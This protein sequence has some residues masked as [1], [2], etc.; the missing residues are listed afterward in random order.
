MARDITALFLAEITAAEGSCPIGLFR[1]YFDSGTLNLWT[2]HGDLSYGGVTYIG[3]N[4]VL[5][6]GQ[7]QERKSITANGLQIQLNGLDNDILEIAEDEPYQDRPFEMYLAVINSAGN[8]VADPYL[9]FEGLMDT[10]K[11]KDD[12]KSITIDTN[13][14]NVLI[15]LER[16][17]DTKYTPE[18]QKRDY[19]NDTFFDFVADIQNK[20][21]IWG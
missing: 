5:S 2:G 12:G 8:V 9:M 21:V 17:L 15:A 10:M 14:E 16:P 20:E 19:P 13:I 18:D 7:V 3:A 6:I 4:G 1:A 11:I